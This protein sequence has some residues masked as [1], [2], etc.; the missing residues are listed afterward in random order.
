VDGTVN[1]VNP[2][3]IGQPYPVRP[4]VTRLHCVSKRPADPSCRRSPAAQRRSTASACPQR[5][6]VCARGDGEGA[7]RGGGVT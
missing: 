1:H 7:E 5:P 6:A 3:D 4:D 2:I